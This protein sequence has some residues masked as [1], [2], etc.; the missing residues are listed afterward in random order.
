MHLAFSDMAIQL[1]WPADW[2]GTQ[3]IN[4]YATIEQQDG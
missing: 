1:V 2:G 3:K 4:I